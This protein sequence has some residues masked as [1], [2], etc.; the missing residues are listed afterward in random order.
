MYKGEDVFDLLDGDLSAG[1]LVDGETNLT[2]AAMANL[3]DE[4]VVVSHLE[5]H[6]ESIELSCSWLFV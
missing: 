1:K 6:L 4:C 5:L 2:I 3:L